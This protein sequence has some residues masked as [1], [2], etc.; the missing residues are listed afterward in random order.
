MY[1]TIVNYTTNNDGYKKNGKLTVKG[2]MVHSTATP[3]IMAETFRERFNKPNLGKSVHGFIDDTVYVQTLPY[4][5]KAGHARYG[6]NSTHIGIE[7]C[8]PKDW[9]SNQAFFIKVWENAVQLFASLCTQFGLTEK[10]IISHKEGYAMGIASNH[11]D[12]DHW[13]RYYGKTMDNFRADVK[14][15]LA[16]EV[17]APAPERT[18]APVVNMKKENIKKVQA[19][20][21]S[22]YGEKLDVDGVIGT[23][24]TAAVKRHHLLYQTLKQRRKTNR[25]KDISGYVKV[26]QQLLIAKGFSVGKLG[27]D[28]DFGENTSAAVKAFQKSIGF[29]GKD[30]DGVV[31]IKTIKALV[32]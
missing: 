14:K 26:V 25:P 24:T 9:T 23:Q 15:V 2:L 8:E 12:P 32:K 5:K 1:K 11:G 21:N 20:L 17:P 29:T 6:A 28:G 19:A 13:W 18:P 4:D 27:A 30:I 3:G 10:N 7:L 16:G 31:G 22:S